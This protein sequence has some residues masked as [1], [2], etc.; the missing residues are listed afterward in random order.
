MSSQKEEAEAMAIRHETIRKDFGFLL[1]WILVMLCAR[2]CSKARHSNNSDKGSADTM[3]IIEKYPSLMIIL[4]I[5]AF[6]I[7]LMIF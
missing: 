2:R 1:R 7:G 4:P 3:S 6:F 5:A